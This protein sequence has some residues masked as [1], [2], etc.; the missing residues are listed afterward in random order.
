MIRPGPSKNIMR[1]R[2]Q[3]WPLKIGLPG[4][5]LVQPVLQVESGH[6]VFIRR[7][8]SVHP[9]TAGRAARR[10]GPA[11]E[12]K[13]KQLRLTNPEDPAYELL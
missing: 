2:P 11:R 6:T 7:Q 8:R 4:C 13:S 9:C 5:F 12:R 10:T 3:E 1:V